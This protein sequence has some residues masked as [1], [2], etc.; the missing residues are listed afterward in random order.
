MLVTLEQ[1]KAHLRLNDDD[2]APDLQLKLR[3]AEIMAA[4]FLNRQLFPDEEAV[5]AAVQA[6]TAGEHPMVVNDLIRAAILLTLGHLYAN[7]EENV[8]GTIVSKLDMGAK[9]LLGFF[10]KDMGV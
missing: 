3:A 5:A 7:R 2:P 9:Q 8:T 6:G 10:R 1:A 4:E